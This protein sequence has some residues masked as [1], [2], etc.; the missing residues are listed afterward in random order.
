MSN[1]LGVA[2]NGGG[3]SRRELDFYATPWEATAALCEAVP[4]PMVIWEPACGDGA[5]SEV[6]KDHDVAV[7][8][9]DIKNRGYRSQIWAKDFLKV[10]L[11]DV[12]CQAIVTNPPFAL[13]EEFIRH[14]LKFT[15]K[16]A[17]LLKAT[18]AN[19]AKRRP[20]FEQ[21]PP[22]HVLPLTWRLDFTGG[23]APTMDC[24]WFVWGYPGQVFRPLPKPTI[25]E[26]LQ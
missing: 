22:S 26:Y 19:A 2:I 6:L 5:M 7:I 13:A 12:G 20:L 11:D 3:G 14:A 17:M 23:G 9:T 24:T 15:P 4:L 10:R 21:H 1:N 18:F 16:V 25:P 8:S